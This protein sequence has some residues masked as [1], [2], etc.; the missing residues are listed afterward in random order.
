VGEGYLQELTESRLC[1][2]CQYLRWQH[3]AWMSE[4]GPSRHIAISVASGGIAEIDGQPSIAEDDTRDPKPTQ[5]RT[6]SGSAVG[7]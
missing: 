1:A 2:T 6:E 7:P 5:G 4:F 3:L